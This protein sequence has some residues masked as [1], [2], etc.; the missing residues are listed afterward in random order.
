MR[1][2][3]FLAA[4]L[5]LLGGLAWAGRPGGAAPEDLDPR[6]GLRRPVALAS[7][8]DGKRLFVANRRSGS[9]SVIDPAGSRVVAETAAGRTLADLAAVPG[10]RQLV[11]ADEAAHELIVFN[12]AGEAPRVAGRLAVSPY[13]VGVRVAPDSKGC[14]VASLW[15]R[16]LTLADLTPAP[17]VR[18]TLDL[19]FAPRALLFLPGGARLLVTDAFGGKLAVV[20]VARGAVESVRELPGHN[21]RGLALTPDGGHVLVTHQVLDPRAR[22]SFDDIHWGNLLTNAVRVLPVADLLDPK[23]DLTASGR[24]IHLGEVGRGGADPTGLAV[25]PDGTS[26]VALS[27]ARE[28]ALGSERA[29]AWERLS[30]GRRP[31][32][33]ALAPAGHRA[34][35]ANTFDDSV[36]VIDLEKRTV[37]ATV[38]LGQMP[39]LS[40]ADRGELLFYDGRL[41]HDGW[42]SCHSCHTDGHTNGRLNDGTADGGFGTPKRVLSL[43]GVRDTAPYAWNGSIPDLEAQVRRSVEQSMHGPKPTAAQV[44]D[45]TAYLRTLT[46]PP[47]AAPRDA[48]A[49]R[50]G[51][52]V[53]ARNGCAG[54]HAPPAY[55]TPKTFDVGLRDESGAGHFN[56]PSL[57]GVGQGGP[58]FH[59]GRAATLRDVFAVHRHQLKG[60]PE[61]GELDDLLEFLRTL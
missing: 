3:L 36:S 4:G 57:R 39:D 47:P 11:A 30:V 2:R 56:P 33:V 8:D 16:R 5:A 43:L 7:F 60:E 51:K 44:V 10:G 26:A 50:R 48:A 40:A 27:G 18:K 59:D 20:D 9:V 28:V 1:T 42:L 13:P 19:P 37:E 38:A 45:L 46:P 54:C 52:E 53:F 14:A 22:T 32:A 12:V 21:L 61:K 35:V 58:Y 34:Y 15:S 25:A 55:T 24:V 31:T 41:S 49:A 6:P 23:A 29:A 17:R